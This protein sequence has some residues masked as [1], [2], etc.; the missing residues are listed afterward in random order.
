MTDLYA[1]TLADGGLTLNPVSGVL[2]EP[3]TVRTDAAD[4]YAV[5]GVTESIIVDVADRQAFEAAVDR[6]RA[7]VGREHFIGTWVDDGKVYVDAV[8]IVWGHADAV[9]LGTERGELAIFNLGTA[10][11]VDLRE[12]AA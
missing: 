3:G 7:F 10:E 11:T 1:L 2:L 8:T 9:R 4:A 12:Q 5:G 6:M